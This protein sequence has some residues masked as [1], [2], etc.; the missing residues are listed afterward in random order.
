MIEVQKT[1]RH[2]RLNLTLLLCC[3]SSVLSIGH[4]AEE[5]HI[6]HHSTTGKLLSSSSDSV[7]RK[8]TVTLIGIAPPRQFC[9]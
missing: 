4:L 7:R 8:T 6:H 1:N 9:L 2:R 5:L 3:D